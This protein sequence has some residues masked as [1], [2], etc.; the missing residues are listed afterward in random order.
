MLT[1]I[2]KEGALNARQAMEAAKGAFSV[3]ASPA[4]PPDVELAT[5]LPNNGGLGKARIGNAQ[6]DLERG[7]HLPHRARV[8][9]GMSEQPDQDLPLGGVTEGDTD[10]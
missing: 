8:Q 1:R 10:R 7:A 3:G 2:S 5:L 4:F 6:P 9:E